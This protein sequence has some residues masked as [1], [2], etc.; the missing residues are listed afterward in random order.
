MLSLTTC[1][2]SGALNLKKLRNR[3]RWFWYGG[4]H[5]HSNVFP[6]QYQCEKCD[7]IFGIL[8]TDICNICITPGPRKKRKKA[9]ESSKVQYTCI[10]SR[11]DH[12]SFPQDI[13]C[14]TQHGVATVAEERWWD[15]MIYG[16]R[17]VLCK[18]REMV[19]LSVAGKG[20]VTCTATS[21]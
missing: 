4:V 19:K 13:R 9:T 18:A 5:T 11:S 7:F 1:I 21:A 8:I 15:I 10:H 12:H 17:W 2:S 14:D 20:K 16:Q 6:F 3:S